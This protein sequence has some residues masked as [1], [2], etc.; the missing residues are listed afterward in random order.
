[1]ATPR[2]GGERRA[3]RNRLPDA[4]I[5]VALVGLSVATCLWQGPQLIED[6]FITFR[7][8]W[9]LCQGSGLVYNPGEPVLGTTSPGFAL[10]LALLSSCHIP[11]PHAA[12]ALGVLG[13]A[14]A[15]L[16]VY[17]LVFRLTRMRMPALAAGFGTALN[18]LFIGFATSGMESS[19]YAAALI[20][21]LLPLPGSCPRAAVLRSGLYLGVATL[22]RPEGMAAFLLVFTLI[23]YHRGRKGVALLASWGTIVLPWIVWATLFYG[24]PMPNSVVAKAVQADISGRVTS[25]AALVYFG[26]LAPFQPLPEL[27]FRSVSIRLVL[28]LCLAAVLLSGIV[29]GLRS[30]IGRG[31]R[32]K[33]QA[34]ILAVAPLGFLGF[35]MAGYALGA[36]R[37]VSIHLWY[38]AALVPLSSAG[39]GLAISTW[40]KRWATYGGVAFLALPLFLQV[41]SETGV[42]RAGKPGLY[43]FMTDRAMVYLDV[44]SVLE[45]RLSFNDVVAL[46]EIG[47]LGWAIRDTR[48]LDT[49]GLVSPMAVAYHRADPGTDSSGIPPG[50]IADRGPDW[51]VSV[52]SFSE[53]L[54]KDSFFLSSY[55]L[56]IV[57]LGVQK[58]LGVVE[59][60][61]FPDYNEAF[62]E[63]FATQGNPHLIVE[64]YKRRA[65]RV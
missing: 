57:A 22:L 24:T 26:I 62:Q 18:G 29:F 14:L 19:L 12:F 36:A 5:V 10:L 58:A 61:F 49:V 25:F 43:P 27:V 52:P 32:E 16:G 54:T 42:A 4:I 15:S 64:V 65:S 2:E 55:Q 38:L 28:C 60:L 46:P 3:L 23:L 31:R 33:W 59:T 1:M 13:A 8:A 40:P 20:F 56:E 11:I 50:L 63:A 35:H 44:G 30:S 47:A 6:S 21:A 34:A 7:Y 17:L 39:L 53:E 37:G 9:N 51:I 45:Q 41:S 48:V